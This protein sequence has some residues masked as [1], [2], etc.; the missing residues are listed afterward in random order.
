MNG[1]DKR[2][3]F[4]EYGGKLEGAQDKYKQHLKDALEDNRAGRR[5]LTYV[6]SCGTL[7]V[8]G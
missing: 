4:L 5:S 8:R 6:A 7:R 3:A 1:G 2:G